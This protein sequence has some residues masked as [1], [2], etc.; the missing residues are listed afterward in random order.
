MTTLLDR[1]SNVAD[2]VEC[3]TKRFDGINGNP[4]GG[5]TDLENK[6]A[7]CERKAR[8]ARDPAKRSYTAA[9]GK[10]KQ[11]LAAMKAQRLEEAQKLTSAADS[12]MR[13]AEFENSGRSDVAKMPEKERLE[14]AYRGYMITKVRDGYHVHKDGHVICRPTT[15]EKAKQEINWLLG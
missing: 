5:F 3:L 4:A 10:F 13:D 15:I 7:D 12:L 8:S 2:A 11:A 14:Q 9:A 6:I 1:I